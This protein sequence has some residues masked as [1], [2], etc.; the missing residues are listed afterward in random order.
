M[1][2][3]RR[4]GI[5]ARWAPSVSSPPRTPAGRS[6]GASSSSPA[7]M[8]WSSCCRSIILEDRIGRDYPPPITHPEHF[9]GFVGVAVAWQ[10]AFLIISRD[11]VRF[12]PLMLAAI[13]EK[14]SFALP[15]F[16]LFAS[17]RVA[18]ATAAVGRHRR[19]ARGAV[20]RRLA[21]DA[22]RASGV[23]AAPTPARPRASS[24]AR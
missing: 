2:S 1:P 22:A 16:A 14:A 10:I 12:R 9:Y 20:H 24:C 7:F 5:I 15:T 8:A 17:G 6:P 19:A 21:G 3:E 18:A 13:V 11:V 23:M 4:P